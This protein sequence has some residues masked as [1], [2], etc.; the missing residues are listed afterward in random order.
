MKKTMGVR[1]FEKLVARASLPQHHGEHCY[2]LGE[3]GGANIWEAFPSIYYVV[4]SGRCVGLAY[5]FDGARILA[6]RY[7]EASNE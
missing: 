3:Y 6:N 1:R 7:E 2:N 5:N 4:R